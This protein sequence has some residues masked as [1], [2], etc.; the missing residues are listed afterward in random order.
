MA[1]SGGADSAL[2]A[3]MAQEVLG[4]AHVRCVTAV[5]PS[6]APADAADCRALAAEW[7]LRWE[8]VQTDEMDDPAYV[9]NGPD[10]CARCKHALMD[11][12]E[13]VAARERG[14]VVLGVNVD[15][16]GDH[17]PG[18]DAA[19]A[20]GAVF[21]FVQAGMTKSDVRAVSRRL[22]LRTWDKPQA[23]CLASRVPYGTPVT[24]STLA[25]VG[26]AE[27]SLRALGFRQCRVRH[28]GRLARVEI[29]EGQLATALELRAQVVAAVRAAGYLHVSL[30]LEGYR[31][32]SLNRALHDPGMTGSAPLEDDPGT[33]SRGVPAA[34]GTTIG[35]GARAPLHLPPC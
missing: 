20:R 17:R 21:P 28:H 4:R 7:S 23:A 22:G 12:L 16:L 19:R 2:L 1:F 27:T 33:S 30:D 15:D 6:L 3:H 31:S 26:Q 25:S 5:S 10:R 8:A 35:A 34:L 29:E 11:V 13:P 32:G 24:L 14:T 18:Q 9:A